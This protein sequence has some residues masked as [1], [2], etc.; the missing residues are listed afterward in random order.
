M[1]PRITKKLNIA[2]EPAEPWG[3]GHNLISVLVTTNE[4]FSIFQ[5]TLVENT[6]YVA[7]VQI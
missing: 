5:S 1:R 2:V 4:F 7:L 3:A 6:Y